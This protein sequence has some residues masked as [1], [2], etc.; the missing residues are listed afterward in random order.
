MKIFLKPKSNLGKYSILSIILF[1]ILLGILFLLINLGER[2]GTT[3][4]S[5]TKLAI[6][7]LLAAL[8]GILSLFTGTISIIKNKD[9]S[10]PV[11]LST[12]IG[13][14]VFF[15]VIGEILFPH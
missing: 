5:N 6:I 11:I 4:F 12:L 7:G 13:F 2:G 14:L 8:F 1:F 15:W 10:I 3:F 9:Y